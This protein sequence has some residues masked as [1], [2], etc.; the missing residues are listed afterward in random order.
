MADGSNEEKREAVCHYDSFY[1]RIKTRCGAQ[2][3]VCVRQSV[4][5]LVFVSNMTFVGS[6]QSGGA[7]ESERMLQSLHNHTQPSDPTPEREATHA[8]MKLIII[9]LQIPPRRAEKTREER[10][11]EQTGWQVD[12]R[13]LPSPLWHSSLFVPFLLHLM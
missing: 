2:V 13:N 3:C 11:R 10:R 12:E 9:R 8:E 6:S 1:G 4:C 5:F 7:E